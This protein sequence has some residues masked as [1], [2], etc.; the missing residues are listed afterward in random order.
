[1][2]ALIAELE[3]LPRQGGRGRPRACARTSPRARQAFAAGARHD[4]ARSRGAVPGIVAARRQRPLRRCH[5]RRRHNYRCRSCRRARMRDRLQRFHDQR[6]HL[7]SDDGEEASPRA[8][9]RAREQVALHLPGRFRW[10][11]PAASN[12]GI[13][14]PRAFRPH[15]LQSGDDV[16]RRHCPDRGGHGL[17]H[18]GRCLRAGDVGRD[19]HRAKPGHDLSRRSAVG[20]SRDRRGGDG[21]RTRRRRRA[22]EE[23]RCGR[24]LR[25][26]RSPCA[27]A[28]PPH[29]RQSEC[30]E[31]DRHSAG[32]ARGTEAR[33]PSSSTVSC[34]S[35]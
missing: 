16:R 24:L 14:G 25:R 7:L 32:Q 17:V 20:Q 3:E 10:R 27:C 11:Q 33:L 6:W 35:I 18:R 2:R 12:R 29:C 21:G 23:I 30:E 9:D 28:V 26:E 1:M 34:R 4:A 15:L 13:S 5:S 31:N 8:G 22:C 19:H